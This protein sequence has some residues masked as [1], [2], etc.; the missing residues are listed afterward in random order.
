MPIFVPANCVSKVSNWVTGIHFSVDVLL[1]ISV[2]RNI[3]N[4]RWTV[5]KGVRV[6]V[7]DVGV[8]E[9][10]PWK[11]PLPT[12]VCELYPAMTS[13]TTL[14]LTSVR[15]KS[16]ICI[17]KSSSPHDFTSEKTQLLETVSFRKCLCKSPEQL[18]VCELYPAMT[19]FTTFPLT[20][21]R[22]KSRPA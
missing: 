6:C 16:L 10:M 5:T 13:F 8:V 9:G 20:S 1:T 12:G 7:V 2:L 14:P 3:M 17:S 22:R 4:V 11:S 15:R 21:V 19:S 18:G